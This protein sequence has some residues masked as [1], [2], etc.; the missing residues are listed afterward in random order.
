MA[1][2]HED[3]STDLQGQLCRQRNCYTMRRS[4]RADRCHGEA[5]EHC[6]SAGAKITRK[7][8]AV[9]VAPGLTQTMMQMHSRLPQTVTK[10][11]IDR[12]HQAH[13]DRTPAQKSA[14]SGPRNV[15]PRTI[16]SCR[17]NV[18]SKPAP[19]KGK[20]INRSI[21]ERYT[22]GGTPSGMQ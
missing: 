16:F 6:C 20:P 17:Q 8:S 3:S 12:Y 1:V 4:R 14:T 7:Q 18:T 15:S 9:A 5:A 11:L 13:R 21:E 10:L 2:R 22:A 19:L